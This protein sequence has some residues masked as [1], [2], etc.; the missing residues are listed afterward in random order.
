MRP[1]AIFI[2]FAVAGCAQPPILD[3]PPAD[4]P[5]RVL[6]IVD[7]DTLDI[8]VP[9]RGYVL[10]QRVRLLGI[11]TPERGQAGYAEATEAL[12]QMVG[13]RRVTLR[14]GGRLRGRYGRLLAYVWL[15]ELDVNIQLVQTGHAKVDM[16]FK[17]DRREEFRKMKAGRYD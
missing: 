4:T 15:G 17:H 11:D 16:R 6:K 9:A 14:Y 8:G 3:A 13:G 2:L 5:Y 10:R 1:L 12:R 7:G